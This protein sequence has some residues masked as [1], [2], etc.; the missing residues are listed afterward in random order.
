MMWR[1][2]IAKSTNQGFSCH[3][4]HSH[5]GKE[6]FKDKEPAESFRVRI[7][8]LIMGAILVCLL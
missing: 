6:A 8:E 3:L 1:E 7:K 2:G 4:K 5:V